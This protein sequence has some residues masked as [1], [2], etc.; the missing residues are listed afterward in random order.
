MGTY[1]D[2]QK[3]KIQRY[4][5]TR[6]YFQMRYK[7]PQGYVSLYIISII[8]NR[9]KVCTYCVFV[10]LRDQ[11]TIAFGFALQQQGYLNLLK[12]HRLIVVDYKVLLIINCATL[13]AF[14]DGI[15]MHCA[16]HCWCYTMLTTAMLTLYIA[17]QLKSEGSDPSSILFCII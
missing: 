14:D 7:Y 16:D 9:G 4:L 10:L 6:K 12:T 11:F 5:N 2:F 17:Y 1:H 3:L 15:Q 13:S 8:I